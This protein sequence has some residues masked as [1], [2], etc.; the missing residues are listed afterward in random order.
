MGPLDRQRRP[1]APL[2][3][4][5]L[6]ARRLGFAPGCSRAVGASLAALPLLLAGAAAAEFRAATPSPAGATPAAATPAVAEAGAAAASGAA[7]SGASA[8]G[9]DQ[10]SGPY[11]RFGGGLDWS[12]PTSFRDQS[13]TSITPPALFGCGTGQNGRSLQA[14][15]SF[16]QTPVLDGAL[17]YRFTSWLRAEA[18]LS[19]RPQLAFRGQSNFLGAGPSQPVNGAVESLAAFGVAYVDLPRIAG[20]RPFLG[21]GIGAA[22]NQLDG[23]TYR[24]PS[25]AANATTTTASGSS[26]GFAYLLTAGVAVPLSERLSLDLAYRFSDLGQVRS[27]SGSATIVRPRGTRS[28]TIAGTEAALQTQGLQVSLRY[29]F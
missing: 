6:R 2:C 3:P 8:S 28:L 14:V 9:A 5:G 20:V 4:G 13:C 21:A 23:V 7:A 17:G 16:S 12:D 22:H 19:W 18:L 24:F 10:R 1:V 11:L 27:R 29:A 15:G 26:S 25:I